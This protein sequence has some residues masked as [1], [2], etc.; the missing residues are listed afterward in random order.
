MPALRALWEQNLWDPDQPI[1]MSGSLISLMALF[2]VLP[3]H[4]TL[5]ATLRNSP[6]SPT[7]GRLLRTTAIRMMQDIIAHH[8][9]RPMRLTLFL[10]KTDYQ[11]ISACLR[12]AYSRLSRTNMGTLG[13][14]RTLHV[15]ATM[16]LSKA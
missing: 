4:T 10:L 11:R 2:P 12:M 16:Y 9:I 7:E 13:H 6:Y 15:Q 14:N 3:V 5:L 8:H 1:A